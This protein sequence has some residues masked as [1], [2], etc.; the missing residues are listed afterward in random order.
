MY[1]TI[2]SMVELA[3]RP[4]FSFSSFPFLSP[5]PP[6]HVGWRGWRLFTEGLPPCARE[7]KGEKLSVFLFF[8]LHM[9]MDVSGLRTLTVVCTGEFL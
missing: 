5:P 8:L 7:K 6:L 4:T 2:G 9:G 1:C 3:H